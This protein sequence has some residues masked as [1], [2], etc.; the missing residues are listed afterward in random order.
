MTFYKQKDEPLFKD[1][2]WAQPQRAAAKEQVLIIGGHSQSLQAPLNAFKHLRKHNLKVSVI[3]PDVLKEVFKLNKS[4]DLNLIF[5]PST[6]AGSLAQSGLEEILEIAN[7]HDCLFI[8]GDLSSN[9]ET[10]QMISKLL[11]EFKVCKIIIGKIIKDILASKITLDKSFNLIL[12]SSQ[13]SDLVRNFGNKADLKSQMPPEAFAKFLEE[14][15]VEFNLVIGQNQIIWTKINSQVC[16]TFTEDSLEQ[17]DK[18]LHLATSCAFYLINHPRQSWSALVSAAWQSK[19]N[20][21]P[22]K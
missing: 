2:I 9:Q 6:P 11:K 13:L 18:L 19:L 5:C 1:L 22:L 12:N 16:A 20:E 8:A 3:L 4:E 21:E 14:L 17:A 7:Q 10:Q 15:D